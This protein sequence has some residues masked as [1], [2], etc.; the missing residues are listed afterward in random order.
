MRGASVAAVPLAGDGSRGLSFRAAMEHL[1]AQRGAS[2][3]LVEAGPTLL[4]SV[5]QGDEQGALADELHVFTGPLVIGHED[6]MTLAGRRPVDRLGEA[7]RWRVVDVRQ[8]DDD[9]RVVYRRAR[10]K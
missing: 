7:S 4:G 9:V 10:T 5:L 8:L 2:T 1:R 3:V 6:A